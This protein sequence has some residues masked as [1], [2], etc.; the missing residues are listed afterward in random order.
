MRQPSQDDCGA[1]ASS[2]TLVETISLPS[3]A[4]GE[5]QR[6]AQFVSQVRREK[7]V[8]VQL[9]LFNSSH[10]PRF[11]D[12]L[13]QSHTK[14]S[15]VIVIGCSQFQIRAFLWQQFSI[16]ARTGELAWRESERASKRVTKQP[17][18]SAARENK[19]N[20]KLWRESRPVSARLDS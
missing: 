5:R 6:T 14:E 13:T 2:S 18:S 19:L 10:R 8:N 12:I 9:N 7:S 20:L 15:D 11:I 3:A 17:E 4:S 16:E 1:R